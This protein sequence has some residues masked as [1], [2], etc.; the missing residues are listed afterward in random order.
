MALPERQLLY[1]IDE[2]LEM[3]RASEERHEY[4]DGRI[5]P[6]FGE[7]PTPASSEFIHNQICINL[8]R[9]VGTQLRGTSCEAL[10][11]NVKV[12]AQHHVNR[13][14]QFS[15][16]DLIVV[17]G[18]PAF[19]DAQKRV[20]TNP[21]AIFEVLSPSTELYDRGEKFL[22][23]RNEM[24]TLTDYI[25]VAQEYPHVDH[26]TRRPDGWLLRTASEPDDAL[27]IANINCTLRLAHV[28]ERVEFP[29]F[30]EPA[31]DE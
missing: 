14:G 23:Y 27:E 2:Y 4:I 30:D 21:V 18:S 5:Y 17:C 28:Y 16:P 13:E 8:A 10:S 15:R 29:E 3:E 25:L 31:E 20:L 7:H 9:E 22:R 1:T 6:A 12:G 11:M 19:H 26:Y 24:P